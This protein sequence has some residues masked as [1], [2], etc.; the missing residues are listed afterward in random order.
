VR[1][2]VVVVSFLLLLVVVVVVVWFL[3]TQHFGKYQSRRLFML[4]R[5]MMNVTRYG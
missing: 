2:K 1:R 5:F 3:A 4:P